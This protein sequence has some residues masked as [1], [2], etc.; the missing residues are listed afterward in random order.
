MTV[1]EIMES[2]YNVKGNS[3]YDA[4]MHIDA[5]KIQHAPDSMQHRYVSEDIPYSLVP[6]ATLGK[7][8]DINSPNM[9]SIINLACMCNSED[10]W[11]TGRNAENLGYNKDKVL[12]AV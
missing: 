11:H 2:L 6:I 12:T 4:I 10:Y 9:D 1:Q 7:T 8:L 3:F 5:Y